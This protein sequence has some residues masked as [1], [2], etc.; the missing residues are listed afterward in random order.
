MSNRIPIMANIGDPLWWLYRLK[1]RIQLEQGWLETLD[2][3]Y[4]GAHRLPEIKDP[5]A[6]KQFQALIE[7]SRSNYV[8]MV[9]DVRMQRLRVD[10]LRLRDDRDD[11]P[12]Q[13]T[14]EI[15]Q[16]NELEAW[17][18]VA[19]QT[20][21]V[22]RRAYW[23][24]WYPERGSQFPVIRVES[25]TQVYVEHV[26]GDPTKRAAAAK[27]WRDDWT[28]A[29]C[30]NVYLPTGIHK[31][32]LENLPTGRRS[33]GEVV[34]QAWREYEFVPNPLGVVPI[35]PMVHR[36]GLTS[37]VDGRSEIEGLLPAQDRINATLLNRQVAEHLA[38]FTQKW[39][40]GL[41]VPEEDGKAV[42]QFKAALD[43][44]WVNED[45]AGRFGAF[46]ASDLDNY[47]KAKADD[48]Q[49]ISVLSFSPRHYFTVQGQAPS[50]DSMKSAE[51]GLVAASYSIQRQF[52]RGLRSTLALAR[53]TIGQDTPVDSEI[54]WAD[55]EYQTVGQ[56]VDAMMKLHAGNIVGP[57]YVLER[58]GA[59]PGTIARE[60]SRRMQAELLG[61]AVNQPDPTTDE[62]V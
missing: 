25:P 13:A 5:E 53:R 57:D 51:A 58:I 55:P 61:D 33:F 19:F 24:V 44:L 21:L 18:A 17:S 14:W 12:D 60:A 32:R 45:P 16:A 56:L 20:A 3:Y 30:A 37:Y 15:W 7:R 62:P 26:P 2:G 38:A 9:V 40:T 22:Q 42:Q 50:G 31:F 29:D 48:I 28:G 23:S 47:I 4:G 34:P 59:T 11:R 8:G 49:D 39:A 41:E 43:E 6:A 35:I 10:G 27:F 36:P 54:V 52:N 1:A 46:P